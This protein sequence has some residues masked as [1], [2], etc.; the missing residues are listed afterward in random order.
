MSIKA[1]LSAIGTILADVEA[2]TSGPVTVEISGPIRIV[3]TAA[4]GKLI[5]DTVVQVNEIQIPKAPASPANQ[6]DSAVS[7]NQ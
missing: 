6:E 2:I 3:V 1:D 4:N 7:I 5:L